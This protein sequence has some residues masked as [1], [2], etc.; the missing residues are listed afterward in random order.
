MFGVSLLVWLVMVIHIDSTGAG[1]TL[2]HQ[3]HHA[4]AFSMRS[5]MSE[6]SSWMLMIVA[7][8]F[9][10]IANSACNVAARSLWPRRQRAIAGFVIGYLCVWL[11]AGIALSLAISYIR[12]QSWVDVKAVVGFSFIAAA[13]WQITPVKRRA[14]FSCHRTMPIAPEG[15]QADCGCVRYGWVIGGSC[16]LNCWA[17]ML[18]CTLT[19]HNL[20][21]MLF[22][23][24]IGIAERYPIRK[25]KFPVPFA[26]S[27][28]TV[29]R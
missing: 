1:L 4:N 22:A 26:S 24:F 9:P 17:W 21:A 18:F 12:T 8:M 14:L 7:M 28:F 29:V 23:A 16:L 13:A 3:H 2:A 20:V 11:I 15:W 5:W 25:F 19:G 10:L 6:T 27:L